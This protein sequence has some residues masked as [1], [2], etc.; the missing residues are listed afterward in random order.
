MDF[1]RVLVIAKDFRRISK[2]DFYGMYFLV[3]S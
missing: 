1:K 3:L 2:E